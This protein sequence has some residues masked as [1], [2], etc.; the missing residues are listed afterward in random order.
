MPAILTL[1][2]E[3]LQK[4]CTVVDEAS[5]NGVPPSV[6]RSVVD[7]RDVKPLPSRTRARLLHIINLCRSPG[8][9]LSESAAG[10]LE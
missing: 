2:I 7:R 1:S 3:H 6:S 4:S 5:G 10:S 8:Y 9:K